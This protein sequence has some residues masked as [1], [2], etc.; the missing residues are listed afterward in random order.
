MVP[1]PNPV[2]RKIAMLVD[3]EN[4][5]P[6]ELG[7]MFAEASR[8]G[9]VVIRRIYGDWTKS[10]MAGWKQ[11]LQKLAFQPVQQFHHTAGKNATDCAIIVDAMDILHSGIVQGFCLG[12]SDS[13]FTRLAIRLREQGCFVMGIGAAK[14]PEVLMVACDEF[15]ILP[16]A[17]QETSTR[18]APANPSASPGKLDPIPLL[19]AAFAELDIGNQW[20]DLSAIGGALRKIDP[21]FRPQ[22]YGYRQLN[23]LCQ[24]QS[25]FLQ[26][27]RKKETYFVRLRP[28]CTWPD[29]SSAPESSAV[30]EITPPTEGPSESKTTW[31]LFSES[32][33]PGSD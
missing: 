7:V 10:N 1:A 12:S 25:K 26:V 30:A 21:E 11:P 3:G 24:G 2:R 5:S 9:Q 16:A 14:T 27:E 20:V 18:P 32:P 31:T 22:V 13:D 33:E 6:R 15:V 4:C 19:A 8:H 17:S 23:L 28:G 29:I